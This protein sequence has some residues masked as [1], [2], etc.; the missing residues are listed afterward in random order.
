MAQFRAT[1]ESGTGFWNH[2]SV[3]GFK[4]RSSQSPDW[5]LAGSVQVNK[6]GLKLHA[7]SRLGRGL[8]LSPK[9]KDTGGLRISL[10]EEH[11]DIEKSV[12]TRKKTIFLYIFFYRE[13]F[14][15]ESFERSEVAEF[16]RNF[17]PTP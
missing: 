6:T 17:Q 16:I 10:K 15:V 12:E 4:R 3:D 14:P 1:I 5:L 2:R 11:R 8:R 9:E 13:H 7:S